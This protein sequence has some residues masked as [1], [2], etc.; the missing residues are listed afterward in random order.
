MAT[1]RLLAVPITSAPGKGDEE[2]DEDED[3]DDERP[4][5]FNSPIDTDATSVS[6]AP[7][8]DNALTSSPKI[9]I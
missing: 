7:T 6:N 1:A 3:E 5:S 8:T 2:A 4:R 9:V